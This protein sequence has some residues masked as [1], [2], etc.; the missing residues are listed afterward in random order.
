MRIEAMLSNARRFGAELFDN[1][2]AADLATRLPLTAA[3]EDFNGVEKV[4]RLPHS[5]RVEGVPD[6]DAPEPGEIG[7]YAPNQA[8]VLY[9]DRVGSWPGLVRIGRFDLPLD[10]LRELPDGFTARFVMGA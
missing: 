2:V 7:Y 6:R 8:L 1:P 4:A 10:E 3:F 9:Y 5:L